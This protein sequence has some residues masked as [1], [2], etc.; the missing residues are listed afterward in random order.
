MTCQWFVFFSG[1]FLLKMQGTSMK[2]IVPWNNQVAINYTILVKTCQCF[3][4]GELSA[5]LG[6][7]VAHGSL[8]VQ[9]P[10]K[11]G[12][13]IFVISRNIEFKMS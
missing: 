5:K 13:G 3:F 8:E 11:N 2:N 6:E 1:L 4:T 7:G 10:N 9:G 12:K